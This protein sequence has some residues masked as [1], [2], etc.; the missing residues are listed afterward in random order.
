MTLAAKK[1]IG[2]SLIMIGI[3]L[4][5]V[6]LVRSTI[7]APDTDIV[8]PANNATSSVVAGAITST[9]TTVPNS[10]FPVRLAIPKL[11]VDTDVQHVG[12]KSSGIMANPTNFTDVGWYKDGTVPG[13]AGSA[14]IAGHVDNALALDGVFKELDTLAAG[15]L[16]YVTRRDGQRVAFRVDRLEYYDYKNAPSTQIF[17]STDGRAHL[18]LVTCA[19]TW[20][21]AEQSYDKRLVVYTTL[22]E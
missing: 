22:A 18:N 5:A 20:I 8:V 3:I 2:I 15:D 19:G 11:G 10:S 6:V 17:T 16:V 9:R 13:E 4:A 12:V 1:L 21:K 7:F 14:V